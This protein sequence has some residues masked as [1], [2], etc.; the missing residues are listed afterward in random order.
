[1]RV[2]AQSYRP[3][4][5]RSIDA[6]LCG[7]STYDYYINNPLYVGISEKGPI[8]KGEFEFRANEM[9]IFSSIE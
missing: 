5:V 8:L 7:G 4:T 6:K 9:M 2:S 3:K 1:M